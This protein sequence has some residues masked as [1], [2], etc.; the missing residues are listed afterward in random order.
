MTRTIRRHGL[1]ATVTGDGPPLLLIHGLGSSRRVWRPITERLSE[2]FTTIAVDLRG[3]G[4]SD[5]LDPAPEELHPAEHAAFLKPLIDDFSDG[6]INVAGNSMGGWIGL[7]IAANG[8]AASLT[9]L[10]PAGLEFDPWVSRSDILVLRRRMS[11][12]LGPLMPPAT[13]LVGKT[14][15]LRD[16]LIG[17]ATANFST[18]DTQVLG[19]AATAM[20]QARG[21]YSSHDG[22]LHTLFDRALEI[23]HEVPVS[24]VW[25]TQDELLPPERQRRV[26]GPPHAKWIVLDECAHVPM[27]DQ[28]R[29]TVQIITDAAQAGIISA[30]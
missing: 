21:F 15:F 26:A 14:P 19:D 13:E 1:V 28:P 2:S 3:H 18:L 27:W 5:W 22:M 16:L 10:C 25:G 8:W 23:S 30:A 24:I 7:E 12:V 17:D 6:A 29:R 9:A 11:Q 4:D 20:R